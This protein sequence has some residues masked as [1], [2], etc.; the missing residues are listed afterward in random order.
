MTATHNDRRPACRRML[1]VL[2]RERPAFQGWDEPGSLNYALSG[3]VLQWMTEHIPAGRVSLETGC[4]YS[5]LVFACLCREHTAVSLFAHEHALVRRW[6]TAHGLETDHVQWLTGRSQEQLPR[7]AESGKLDV[8][9]IDGDHA[10]PAPFMDWYWTADRLRAGGVLLVDDI[11][12]ATGRV[13]TEF[14]E[15]ERERW[16]CLEIID[17]TAVFQRLGNAPA[18]RGVVWTAQPWVRDSRARTDGK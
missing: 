5:T 3:D 2:L 7:L 13:L 11:Q 12:L 17:K 4:G 16:R 1:E 14:L 15:A 10:F 8:V 9:L 6:A 18:A